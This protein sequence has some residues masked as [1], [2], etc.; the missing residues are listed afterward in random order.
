MKHVLTIAGHDLSSGAGVTKD[1][2]IFLALGLHPLSIP[3]SFVIQGPGGV[4]NLFPTPPKPFDGMLKTA[5]K[6]VRLDGI[7]VGVLGETF[8]V[9]T[10]SSFLKE[11]REKPIVVDPVIAS[12]NGFR[13]TSDADLRFMVRHIFPLSYL[14][15]PNA[16]EASAILGKPIRNAGEME[17]AAVAL[18][19]LGPRNVLLKGG[20]LP[21]DPVDL[22]F[23]G[24]QML[25]HKKK[26]MEREV[27][28]T[29]CSLSSLMLSFIVLGY[30][31][32]EA[33]LEAENLMEELL[34]ESYKLKESGYWY[35]SLTRILHK[36]NERWRVLESLRDASVTLEHLN[37]VTLIPDV[38]MNVGYAI[39]GALGI[40][41]VAAFPG[42]IGHSRG[43]ICFKGGPEFGASS[44][45]AKLILTYMKQYPHMRACANLRYD[46]GLVERA[47]KSGM[48]VMRADRRKEPGS[49]K[50]AIG[51]GLDSSVERAL[52]GA[53]SPPD[54]VYD[55]GD[56]GKEAIIRLFA[57]DPVELLKKMEKMQSWKTN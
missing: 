21:G 36:G 4:S 55:T 3:T 38:Q 18:S 49:A 37:M 5:K 50:N 13:L 39:R 10:V 29:G 14:V 51:Q 43:K 47:K 44:Y 6:E 12:K 20:H 45:V 28:G 54:I 42:R 11:Y 48:A 2:E 1:L 40:E 26:R 9:K 30:P 34:K 15:T 8:Q 7:K 56:M 31:L 27:H 19:Q 57:R 25:T 46:R 35:T 41:D 33:F 22:L 17:R 23:D 53:G 32:R 16:D 24:S 52:K